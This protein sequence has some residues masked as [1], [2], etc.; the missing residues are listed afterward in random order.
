MIKKVIVGLVI[1]GV[2]L[3]VIGCS[4]EA[5]TLTPDATPIS[6]PTPPSTPT[7]ADNPSPALPSSPPAGTIKAIWIDALTEGDIVSIS[8][9]EVQENWNNNFKLETEDGTFNFM[10]YILKGELIVRA[11]VCPPCKSV[12]F[13]LDDDILVCDRCATTFEAETGDG[14]Q[15]AC[16]DFPKASV[17][18]EIID[19]S[20]VMSIDDLVTAHE[21][22]VKPG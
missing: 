15:G 14:I 22:T 13:S 10:A 4:S 21:E 3:A 6:N 5:A 19:T 7:P 16:V 12:G 1:L 8:L 18:Y 9:T 2:I 20:I 17:A 11:N